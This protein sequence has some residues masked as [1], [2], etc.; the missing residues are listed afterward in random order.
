[1][2]NLKL[3]SALLLLVCASQVAASDA[4][5]ATWA[6]EKQAPIPQASY[7]FIDKKCKQ[8]D[9][10]IR[11]K[12]W[13]AS[14]QKYWCRGGI[15]GLVDAYG[16]ENRERLQELEN[17]PWPGCLGQTPYMMGRS[18]GVKNRGPASVATLWN[19][20]ILGSP[21]YEK[22]R[23]SHGTDKEAAERLHFLIEDSID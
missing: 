13:L 11:T 16:N 1:M 14:N 21:V 9:I 20:K 18:S 17:E 23:D 15:D 4:A 7:D 6:D 2:K 3:A 10:R 8:L 22:L 12:A 5:F 19:L